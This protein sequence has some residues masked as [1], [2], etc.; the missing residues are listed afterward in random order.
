MTPA[1]RIA[2][3]E[4]ELDKARHRALDEARDNDRLRGERNAVICERN[5]AQAELSEA[6]K[7]SHAQCETITQL[8]FEVKELEDGA[9]SAITREHAAQAEVAAMREAFKDSVERWERAYIG[10]GAGMVCADC[11]GRVT[12]YPDGGRCHHD[13]N[14][15]VLKRRSALAG[16]AGR[17][18][19]ERVPLLEAVATDAHELVDYALHEYTCNVYGLLREK[20]E[21]LRAKLQPLK[22]AALDE[23]GDYDAN[24]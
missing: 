7:S 24:G 19:T 3:L 14:C 5:A 17:A 13:D 21:A 20:L 6:R 10:T 22:S 4:A 23:K 18:I 11:R 16:D 12:Y 15:P 8:E 1:D 9:R 2:Q